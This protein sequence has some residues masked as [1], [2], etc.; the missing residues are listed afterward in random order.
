MARYHL[1]AHPTS[2][3]RKPRRKKPGRILYRLGASRDELYG[4]I[5]E[6]GPGEL[7]AALDHYVSPRLP[8]AAE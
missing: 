1:N 4:L 5:T 7:S 6:I 2:V 3:K 8:F